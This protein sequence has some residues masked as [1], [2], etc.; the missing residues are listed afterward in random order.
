MVAK[1]RN[2]ILNKFIQ[3]VKILVLRVVID[4]FLLDGILRW[5]KSLIVYNKITHY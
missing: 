1:I 2:V 4:Q 5:N 3:K